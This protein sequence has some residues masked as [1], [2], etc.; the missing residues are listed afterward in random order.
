MNEMAD[1]VF[2]F[3][4]FL[5]LLIKYLLSIY[6]TAVH[7]LFVSFASIIPTLKNFAF[8]PPGISRPENDV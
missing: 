7:F 2:L 8:V 1:I 5:I 4:F 6:S 3:T